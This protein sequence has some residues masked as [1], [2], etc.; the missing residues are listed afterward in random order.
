MVLDELGG[1]WLQDPAAVMAVGVVVFAL[2]GYAHAAVASTARPLRR[3]AALSTACTDLMMAVET[4]R[5]DRLRPAARRRTATTQARPAL[6]V[7]KGRR[8]RAALAVAA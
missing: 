7:I 4:A 3:E 5:T 2:F 6:R 8:T 1:L